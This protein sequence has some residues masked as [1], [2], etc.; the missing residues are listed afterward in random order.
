M[1]MSKLATAVLAVLAIAGIAS[2]HGGPFKPEFQNHQ[3]RVAR[4]HLEPRQQIPMHEVPPHV[5]VWLTDADLKI[6]YPD[7]RS[8]VQHFHAGQTLWVAMGKHAGE[9]ISA[10]AVEFVVIEPLAEQR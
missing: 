2:A 1:T 8:D 7:G 5:A 6:S 3:V 4:V 10:H 9:N